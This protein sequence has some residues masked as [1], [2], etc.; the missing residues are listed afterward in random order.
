MCGEYYHLGDEIYVRERIF[1]NGDV[2][3][4]YQGKLCGREDVTNDGRH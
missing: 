1:R 4:L 2:L 3:Y